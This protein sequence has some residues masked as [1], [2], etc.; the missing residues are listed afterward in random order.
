MVLGEKLG[1]ALAGEAEQCRKETER[2]D[3]PSLPNKAMPLSLF[4][5]FIA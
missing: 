2:M 4:S 1:G 3:L 5:C